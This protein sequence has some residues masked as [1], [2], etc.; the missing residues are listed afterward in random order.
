M[1]DE[2]FNDSGIPHGSAVLTVIQTGVQYDCDSD[3]TEPQDN[4]KVVKR[5]KANGAAGG[6]FGIKDF[7]EGSCTIQIATA[8][9]ASVRAG[10]TF[11]TDKTGAQ[12]WIVVNASRRSP[13]EGYDVQE[14]TFIEK[15]N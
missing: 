7:R 10:N 11:T 1:A 5:N 6:S 13:K 4:T 8:A 14:I 15:L 2:Q 12:V 3:F 9:T